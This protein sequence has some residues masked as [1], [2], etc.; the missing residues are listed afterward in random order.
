[1]PLFNCFLL[2]CSVVISGTTPHNKPTTGRVVNHRI[3]FFP[4]RLLALTFDDGPSADVTPRILKTLADHKAHATFFVLGAHA[5]QHPELL[6]RMIVEGHAVGS[7]SYSHPAKAS[8]QQAAQELNKT[9]A[10]IRAAIGRSPTLFRPPYGIMKG[11]LA[12][13]ALA[14]DYTVVLWTISSADTRPISPQVIANNVIHTPNPGDIVLIHD[15]PGHTSSANALP[16]ILDELGRAGYRFVTIPEL[17]AAWD[18]WSK[19]TAR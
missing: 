10:A 6:R 3:R 1:M 12:R 15:G 14:R 13:Q 17:I 7:H 19:K 8:P 16:Q 4:Q 5:R 11:N 18:A 9:E 2:V